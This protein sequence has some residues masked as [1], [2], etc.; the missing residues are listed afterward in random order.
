MDRQEARRRVST[1]WVE[2]Y[3]FSFNQ[4]GFIEDEHARVRAANGF[5]VTIDKVLPFN[6]PNVSGPV[7]DFTTAD[8]LPRD[9]KI[10]P[11]E[12]THPVKDAPDTIGGDDDDVFGTDRW[13]NV[14]PTRVTCLNELEPGKYCGAKCEVRASAK[15]PG[16]IYAICPN[17]KRFVQRDGKPGKPATGGG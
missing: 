13:G 10:I 9:D 1:E 4:L 12:H 5:M 2:I 7:P 16:N 6:A 11:D 14:W 17:C 8:K 3:K 15:N